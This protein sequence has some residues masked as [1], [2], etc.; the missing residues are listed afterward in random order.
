MAEQR[1][2]VLAS[3]WK[4]FQ[5]LVGCVRRMLDRA[6][7]LIEGGA[8]NS[9]VHTHLSPAFAGCDECQPG[10]L[11]VTRPQRFKLVQGDTAG[12]QAFLVHAQPH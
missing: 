10:V 1:R 9:L 12:E 7:V 4:P 2:S 8:P 11:G 6:V 5:G 3:K